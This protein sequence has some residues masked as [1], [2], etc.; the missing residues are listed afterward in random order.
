MMMVKYLFTLLYISDTIVGCQSSQCASRSPQ[1]VRLSL[2][3][4][5]ISC[6]N[7]YPN[8]VTG[9]LPIEWALLNVRDNGLLKNTGAI[10]ALSSCWSG[11]L[12][13]SCHYVPTCQI[14]MHCCYL[15]KIDYYMNQEAMQI[16]NTEILYVLWRPLHSYLCFVWTFW[17]ITGQNKTRAL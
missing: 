6:S 16:K 12:L 2:P 14:V 8:P 1:P 9:L 13:W 3:R 10:D 4:F 5:Y 15:S 7:Y 17:R 11:F